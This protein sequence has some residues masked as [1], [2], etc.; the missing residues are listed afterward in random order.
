MIYL[1]AIL[2]LP[3][4]LAADD[5]GSIPV[6]TWAGPQGSGP[7]TY[8]EWSNSIGDPGLFESSLIDEYPSLL[9]PAASQ[10]ASICIIVNSVLYP[11]IQS[12]IQQYVWDLTAEGYFVD[13]HTSLNGT[14]ESL[15]SFLQSKYASGMDGFV[16]IGDLPVPWYESACFGG[17]EEFPIDLFYMD[18]DGVWIDADSDGMYDDHTG[19]I[20]PDVWMGRLTASNMTIGGLSEDSIL[21]N[22]FHKNHEYRTQLVSLNNRALV[23]V[24]DDWVNWAAE[25]SGDVGLAYGN[26]TLISNKDLTFAPDYETRLTDNY[27]SILVCTHASPSVQQFENTAGQYSWTYNYEIKAIDPVANFV[28]LFACSA[29][30]YTRSDYLAGWYAFADSYGLG[31]V[32]STKTGAMLDFDYFYEPLGEGRSIGYA[33]AQWFAIKAFWASL[34]FGDLD[35]FRCWHYGM[36]LIGDPTLTLNP[37]GVDTDA[38]GVND[39][40]DNCPFAYNSDQLDTDLDSWGDVCDNCP[41]VFNPD[42]MDEDEDGIGDLC[43]LCPDDPIN[44]P[45]GDSICF[46]DDNCPYDYNPGQENVDADTL[47]DVCDNCPSYANDDQADYDS[48]GLGD[49]CDTCLTPDLIFPNTWGTPFWASDSSPINLD[50]ECTY[51]PYYQV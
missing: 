32:G 20:A 12:S 37:S 9:D 31:V 5:Y 35:N 51:A 36:T 22:Y 43:D 3:G 50:W 49:L 44:D 26:R 7:I 45:D 41:T 25:W 46:A 13:L 19:D 2:M 39:T 15:R 4:I 6:T 10:S 48:D 47:G 14:P 29:A 27:E 24:D 42:Q 8:L 1:L 34:F 33:F 17:Y 18:L 30:R 38:D 11:Q 21:Q 40:F 28:N 23:Y 16:L